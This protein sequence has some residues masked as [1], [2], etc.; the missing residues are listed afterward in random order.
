MNNCDINYIQK[1]N[2]RV[3]KKKS[4]QLLLILEKIKK[5]CKTFCFFFYNRV[6]RR[7]GICYNTKPWK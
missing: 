1:M 2:I 4:K 7:D 5:E 6:D 3:F